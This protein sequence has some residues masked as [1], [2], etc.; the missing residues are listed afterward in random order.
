MSTWQP[1]ACDPTAKQQVTLISP[2]PVYTL[3]CWTSNVAEKAVVDLRRGRGDS[4]IV[5]SEHRCNAQSRDLVVHSTYHNSELRIQHPGF[6]PESP[7]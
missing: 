7:E 2:G 6:A 3:A 1:S 5:C 4:I